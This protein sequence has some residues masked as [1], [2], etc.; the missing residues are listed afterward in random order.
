MEG[1]SCGGNTMNLGVRK[2]DKFLSFVC[3][4]LLHDIGKVVY[5]ATCEK[6]HRE[7]G[8]EFLKEYL[9]NAI[10]Y[11]APKSHHA[12]DADT[13]ST[14]F[15]LIWYEADNLASS[16]RKEI[17]EE[18]EEG[19]W[20]SE[21]PLASPFSKI[22]HPVTQKKIKQL[23]YLPL[24]V[25]TPLPVTVGTESEAKANQEGYRKVLECF[26]KDFKI[27]VSSQR[28]PSVESLLMIL[29]KHFSTIPSLTLKI[30]REREE[31][32]EKHPDISLYDHLKLTA[33]IAGCMY[34]YYSEVY[35]EKWERNELL[36]D[37]ILDPPKDTKR[38]LL[39]GGDISGIQRFIYTITSKGA[40]KSLKGRSFFLELLTEHVISE[41][42]DG[43]RLTRCNLIFSGGG[44]FYILSHNTERAKEAINKVKSEVEEYLFDKFSGDLGLHIDW[45][46]FDKE[47]FE[48]ASSLWKALVERLERSK[49]KKWRNRLK[50]FLSPKMP[51]E[52]CYTEACRICFRD[53]KKLEELRE[54]EEIKVC[55]SCKVQYQLGEE[56]VKISKRD[57]P[58]LY[59]FGADVKPEGSIRICNA[60]YKLAKREFDGKADERAQRVYRI[61]DFSAKHYTDHPNSTP[62]YL[63]IYQHDDL[64]ELA[65]IEKK[66]FGLSRV[67]VLR[68]DVDNLG[69]IF[70]TAVP[71]GDRTFSRM[72]S[73]S[74]WLNKF[75]KYHLNTIVEGC[76]IEPLDVAGRDVKDKG[77]MLSIVYSGGDDLFIIGHWLDIMEVAQD[78]NQN[79]REF[80]GNPY[81][82]LS[83]GIAVN[84][85]KHPVYQFAREAEEREKKAK[86]KS[87]KDSITLLTERPFR[88]S[89]SKE[90]IDRV[91]LFR[92]L[93]TVR[94]NFLDAVERGK[95]SRGF[96]YRLFYIATRFKDK[97][98]L[99]L[100]HCAYL[101]ART[102]FEKC[103]RADEMEVKRLIMS[104]NEDTWR[105]TECAIM[106][107][108][109]L[110]RKGGGGEK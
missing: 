49:K 87:E 44:Q 10:V 26:E 89:E 47:G 65:D 48:D 4:A 31:V 84:H 88:W 66:G 15:G 70:S 22:Q 93:L 83:G 27:L 102:D 16:E 3:G 91:K 73:I 86:R 34:R 108:L 17:S 20:V 19:K 23:K 52:D 97:K 81:I 37:E 61:N 6:N 35:R 69:L 57:Y 59:R 103:S 53:D 95:P 74:R 9:D 8:E 100:P 62:L 80:T 78:I 94:E 106:W 11:N 42:I 36:K 71:E 68:M 72:A 55:S 85:V 40:L 79:F 33:G 1:L 101:L 51:D 25:T 98:V 24:R 50:D 32:K 77:R 28:L 92:R 58:I 39:I 56:L 43:L 12:K 110:M 104:I 96:F 54:E 75:F 30:Y 105:I 14:N 5:R 109:M 64:T 60:Y 21:V 45:V 67:G 90:V 76:E 107:I 38:F 46:E 29:E 99:L 13:F 82:T 63:G 41:L 18:G 2:D 7:L